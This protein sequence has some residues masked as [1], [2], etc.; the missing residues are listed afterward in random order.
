MRNIYKILARKPQHKR[1]VCEHVRRHTN[2]S[3]GLN[4]AQD[5]AQW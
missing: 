1:P 2:A 5:W 4:V 3:E